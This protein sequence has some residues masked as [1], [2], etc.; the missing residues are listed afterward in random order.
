MLALIDTMLQGDRTSSERRRQSIKTCDL[1]TVEIP[2]TRP[3]LHQRRSQHR[4]SERGSQ[5]KADCIKNG[6]TQCVHCFRRYRHRKA[7]NPFFPQSQFRCHQEHGNNSSFLSER[8]VENN[9]TIDPCGVVRTHRNQDM[10]GKK[11]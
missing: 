6:H 5:D 8:R 10:G 3:Q 4:P 9:K 11:L 1:P 7:T 2:R